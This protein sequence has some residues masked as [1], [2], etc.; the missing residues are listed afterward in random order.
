MKP[1]PS[2]I[3]LIVFAAALG[4]TL[5]F[6]QP[7]DDGAYGRL[8]GDGAVQLDAGAA[9][10]R[11]KA[12]ATTSLA[13]RYLHTVGLYGTALDFLPDLS[14]DP[15]WS[16][17][18]GVELRP[19]FLPRFLSNYERGPARWDLALDSVSLRFGAVTGKGHPVRA[20]GLEAAMGVGV[21]FTRSV[22]GL[23]LSATGALRWS[24]A[25]FARDPGP[26]S[27][28]FLTIGWQTTL[29]TNLVHL[30]DRPAR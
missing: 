19:L 4:P 15:R 14:E 12:A 1:G 22:D 3:T 30:W 9:W 11:S 13:V 17:S 24:H 10:H 8:N 23:W 26:G 2:A 28:I 18:Y 5:A 16:V 29:D 21:P 7:T 25:D 27:V 20:Q 6:A